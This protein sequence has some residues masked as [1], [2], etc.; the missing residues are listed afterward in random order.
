VS[1]K[2][3]D[4]VVCLGHTRAPG[5]RVVV[6]EARRCGFGPSGRNGGFVNGW[7]DKA[8]TVAA[9]AGDD[10]ALA[11]GHAAQASVEAIGAWCEAQR[12]DA[13]YTAAPHLLVSAAPA[14]DGLWAE[15]VAGARRLGASDEFAEL[16]PPRS[17]RAAARRSSAAGRCCAPRP[18][19][20]RRGWPS[21]CATASWAA[22]CASTRA[23]ACSGWPAGAAA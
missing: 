15:G 6:L 1:G 10:A 17:P 8:G 14:Q 12:V 22:G 9:Q 23:R 18:R 13:W 3:A 21:G 7:W 19:C 11:L 16:T 5:A 4:R 20:T 2:D